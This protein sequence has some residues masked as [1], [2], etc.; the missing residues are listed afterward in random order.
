VLEFGGTSMAASYGECVK[1]KTV[2]CHGVSP[3]SKKLGEGSGTERIRDHP[4]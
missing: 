4:L 2:M 3:K 1:T